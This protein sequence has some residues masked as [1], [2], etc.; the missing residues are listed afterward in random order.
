MVL[1]EHIAHVR[2]PVGKVLCKCLWRNEV[3]MDDHRIMILM[4]G[5]T[6]RR[7]FKRHVAAQQD[8]GGDRIVA[9]IALW[10]RLVMLMPSC[11]T[12]RTV[13]PGKQDFH[14][15]VSAAFPK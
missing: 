3:G 14:P 5:I 2:R 13:H 9:E 10:S 15:S 8:T 6:G 4:N 12:H 1:D 7:F 11:E